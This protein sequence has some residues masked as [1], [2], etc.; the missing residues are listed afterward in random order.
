MTLNEI[1]DKIEAAATVE[2]LRSA[3]LE[4]EKIKPDDYD[5]YD[6]GENFSPETENFLNTEI[7][8]SKRLEEFG[9]F[10]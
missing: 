7:Y 5:D 8:L 4:L 10:E 3:E 9:V 6:D 2:D 1:S